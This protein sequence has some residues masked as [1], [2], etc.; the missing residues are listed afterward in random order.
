MTTNTHHPAV[1]ALLADVEALVL[2]RLAELLP[3]AAPVP[4]GE[5][6]EARA[7]RWLAVY[8]QLPAGRGRLIRAARQI[9]LAEGVGIEAVRKAICEAKAARG[10]RYGSSSPR[11]DTLAGC[12]H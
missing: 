5:P 2:R 9:A 1:A 6:K 11:R 12:W 7:A 10:H 3:A 4:T 8:D